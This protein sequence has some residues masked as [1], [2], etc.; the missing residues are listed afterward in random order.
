MVSKCDRQKTD[1]IILGYLVEW[2]LRRWP[3]S[4][5][6]PNFGIA[7]PP[8]P[9]REVH[10]GTALPFQNQLKFF[11]SP[12]AFE[13]VYYKLPWKNSEKWHSILNVQIF[14]HIQFNSFETLILLMIQMRSQSYQCLPNNPIKEDTGMLRLWGK[15]STGEGSQKLQWW[16]QPHYQSPNLLYIGSCCICI[17]RSGSFTPLGFLFSPDTPTLKANIHSMII[18]LP[19]SY[20]ILYWFLFTE[21]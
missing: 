7:S 4:W 5:K 19:A 16:A 12:Q 6:S 9:L 17:Q 20:A 18:R 1:D 14:K 3:F 10:Q 13:Y 8:H 15:D 2:L 21:I 11:S